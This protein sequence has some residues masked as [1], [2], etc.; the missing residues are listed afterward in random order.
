M[1]LLEFGTGTVFP[2]HDLKNSLLLLTSP[3]NSQCDIVDGS[4]IRLIEGQPFIVKGMIDLDGL[5]SKPLFHFQ[6][7]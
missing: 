1:K 2:F 5:L 7:S 6:E 3:L 4:I